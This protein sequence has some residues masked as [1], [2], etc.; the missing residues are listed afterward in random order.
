MTENGRRKLKEHQINI[1]VTAA[2]RH[3]AA[4]LKVAEDIG[5]R[6]ADYRLY[7]ALD[8]LRRV[9]AAIKQTRG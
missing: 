7:A 8:T 6:N 4:A 1:H 2:L 3:L 5:D 9:W